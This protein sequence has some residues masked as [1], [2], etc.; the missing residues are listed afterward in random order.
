MLENWQLLLH[1]TINDGRPW[2]QH[3]ALLLP[4]P[5][6]H[7]SDSRCRSPYAAVLSSRIPW[8]SYLAMSS[9]PSVWARE[10]RRSHVYRPRE[11]PL[12]S[13]VSM[14]L[15]SAGITAVDRWWSGQRSF[16]SGHPPVTGGGPV[17]HRLL[18]WLVCTCTAAPRC[19]SDRRLMNG[20]DWPGWCPI[21]ARTTCDQ[22]PIDCL[23]GFQATSDQCPT[24]VRR[25][26]EQR[27]T[28]VQTTSDQ[29]PTN[30]RPTVQRSWN[31]CH[32]RTTEVRWWFN[33]RRIVVWPTFD[34]PPTDVL[35][36]SDK[37]PTTDHRQTDISPPCFQCLNNIRQHPSFNAQLS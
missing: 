33:Q 14:R 6:W 17:G 23:T 35:S 28:N 37:R 7:I 36:M 20:G 16:G 22:R 5:V 18:V 19:L 2:Q 27:P 13:A 1:I 26:S 24:N 31:L 21:N 8:L 29:R 34:E 4:A 11:T 32:H 12:R 9:A 25:T 10:A 30:T 3:I 15:Q